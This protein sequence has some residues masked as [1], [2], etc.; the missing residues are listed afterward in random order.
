MNNNRN[1]P[2]GQSNVFALGT[3]QNQR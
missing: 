3:S 1:K 2:I